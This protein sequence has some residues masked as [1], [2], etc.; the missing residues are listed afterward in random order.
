MTKIA[1]CPASIV[2]WSTRRCAATPV[3]LCGSLKSIYAAP[4]EL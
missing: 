1:T 4:Q 3:K 2:R